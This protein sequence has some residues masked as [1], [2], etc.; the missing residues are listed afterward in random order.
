MKK[1]IGL[2]VLVLLISFSINAQQKQEG[3]RKGSDFTPE[4]KATLKTKKM[5]LALDLTENQE[6][7]VYTFMKQTSEEREATMAEY[8]KKKENGEEFTSEQRYE[9]QLN[10]LERQ[11]EH[12]AAMKNILSE[13]QY[14][15]WEK[16][17]KSKMKEG[18]KKMAH[19]EKN[20]GSQQGSQNKNKS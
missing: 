4:Q 14:E 3:N 2:T 16:T 7:K 6:Q 15:K 19:K 18:R 17:M 9:M 8:K 20:K 5:V 1:I 12:K 13:E 11:I 10:R